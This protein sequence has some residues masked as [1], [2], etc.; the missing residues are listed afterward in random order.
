[1]AFF[2]PEK[3]IKKTSLCNFTLLLGG[4]AKQ[5]VRDTYVLEH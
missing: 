2:M 1:M 4:F 3:K 5:I